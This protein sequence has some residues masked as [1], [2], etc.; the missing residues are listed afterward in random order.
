M[1]SS[2]NID[3][4]KKG[5]LVLGKDP[6]QGLGDN[7]LTAQ[8]EHAIN[9]NDQK[10]GFCLCLHYNGANSYLFA[11]GVEIYKFKIIDSEINIALEINRN[12]Y[13]V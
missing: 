12:K 10:K 9:F 5:V 6:M 7:T 2:E 1:S 13:Y 3:N 11:K 4:R 8:K